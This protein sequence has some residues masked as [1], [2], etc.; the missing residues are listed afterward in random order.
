MDKTIC[1]IGILILLFIFPP[2]AI[3]GG[4]VLLVLNILNKP[5]LFTRMIS[6]SGAQNLNSLKPDVDLPDEEVMFDIG[7]IYKEELKA[8]IKPDAETDPDLIA[9]RQRINSR[10]AKNTEKESVEIKS[11]LANWRMRNGI[12]VDL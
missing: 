1:G 6:C 2:I 10:I 8:R 7:S 3:I 5:D 12:K 11:D 4:I 9:L